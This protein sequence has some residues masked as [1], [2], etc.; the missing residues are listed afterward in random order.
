MEYQL[1]G[2]VIQLSSRAPTWS[3]CFQSLV[4]SR[5]LVGPLYPQGTG[6]DLELLSKLPHTS[7]HQAPPRGGGDIGQAQE[8]SQQN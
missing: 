4:I 5:P 2:Q 1:W 3:L 8:P 6:S 7:R